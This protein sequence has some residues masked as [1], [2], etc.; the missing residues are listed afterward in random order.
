MIYHPI[1]HWSV[2]ND[3]SSPFVRTFSIINST[4]L[5]AFK[6]RSLTSGCLLGG[7]GLYRS[8]S[9]TLPL[10][11]LKKVP[12]RSSVTPTPV[13]PLLI[14][15]SRLSIVSR[16]SPKIKT[17]LPFGDIQ[18]SSSYCTTLDVTFSLVPD[19]FPLVRST[20]TTL[21]PFSTT[22]N[23]FYLYYRHGSLLT[24]LKLIYDFQNDYQT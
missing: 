17:T 14:S 8:C 5:V 16:S 2:Y 9:E 6:Y 22:M 12:R 3:S 20:V 1:S 4:R 23:P 19:F 13:Y 7:W 10:L 15:H 11:D 18:I 24:T 21:G